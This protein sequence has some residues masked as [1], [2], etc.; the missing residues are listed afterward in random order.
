MH[1]VAQ[2]LP[3]YWLVQ[4]SRIGLGEHAWKAT[5]WVVVVAWTVAAAVLARRAYRRD[6]ERPAA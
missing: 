4:A 3:S 2:G 5:G 6:A 1:A